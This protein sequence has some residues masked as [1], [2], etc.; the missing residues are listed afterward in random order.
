MAGFETHLRLERDRSPHTVRAYV[1]DAR[2]V[3]AFAAGRGHAAPEHVDVADLRAWL[4]AQ[5]AADAARSSMARRA[6]SARAFFAWAHRAGLVPADPAMRVV[7]PRRG[8]TLPGV[9]KAEHAAGL[10]DVAGVR[11]DDGDPATARDRA[12]LELLYATGVRVGEL[13]GLDVDDVDLDERTA[14][15]MGKGSKERVVPFGVPAVAALRAWLAARPA[16]ATARSGPA[17]F[18]GRRGGRLGDRAVR[19]LVHELL[20][21]V[22]DAPD[23]APHGLRH[24]AATHLLDAGADLRTV[25]ELLGHASLATTQLYTHVSLERLRAS[26]E[27]AHPRA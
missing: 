16:L 7:V 8:R 3:L 18:L 15:V 1:R 14:R 21:H 25:Q 4:G 2:D 22:P 6:A 23:L 12:V 9:L 17:L 19:E 11:A 20:T 26:Y 5:A 24:S 27:Q 10:L 13:V